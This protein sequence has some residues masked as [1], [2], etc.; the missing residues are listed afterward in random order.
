MLPQGLQLAETAGIPRSY[1]S[2]VNGPA[3]RCLR[4]VGVAEDQRCAKCGKHDGRGLQGGLG[5]VGEIALP[6]LDLPG[7]FRSMYEFSLPVSRGC[8]VLSS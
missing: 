7:S 3:G 2:R 6:K 5:A 4:S 1:G 8:R